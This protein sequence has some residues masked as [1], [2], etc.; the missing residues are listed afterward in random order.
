MRSDGTASEG[1]PADLRQIETHAVGGGPVRGQAP[2]GGRIS[3]D[4]LAPALLHPREP[5]VASAPSPVSRMASPSVG[6]S[7]GI[8]RQTSNTASV[9][10]A[11]PSR[12]HRISSRGWLYR[13][14][15]SLSVSG[16]STGNRVGCRAICMPWPAL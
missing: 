1:L 12:R 14:I 5:A 8:S 4:A 6:S 15:R 9:S 13:R 11:R 16:T 7:S 3:D 10:L 2:G